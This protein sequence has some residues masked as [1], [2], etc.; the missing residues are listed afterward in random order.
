MTHAPPPK[1]PAIVQ[2]A[3]API[4]PNA[5]LFTQI[6]VERGGQAFAVPI[7]I[8]CRLDGLRATHALL[9]VPS[10]TATLFVN[11]DGPGGIDQ[12]QDAPTSVAP[13]KK[14]K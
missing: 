10:H 14:A 11:C 9:S 3:P 12:I 4:D 2:P 1:P 5:A 6:I 8:P 7:G 13:L